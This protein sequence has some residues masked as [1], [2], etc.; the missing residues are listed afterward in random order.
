MPLVCVIL[1]G[2]GHT[3]VLI[4]ALQQS[5]A[6]TLYA[7][8]EPEPTHWGQTLYDVPIRGDDAFLPQLIQEGV[9]SFV[10]GVGSLGDATLRRRLFDFGLAHGLEAI[11]VIHPNAVISERAQLGRGVQVLAG[12]IINAGTELGDN[13]LI[14]T[15][16]IIEHDCLIE[17]DVH[18]ATGAKLAGTVRVGRGAHIGAG[19]SIRHKITIGAGAVVGVGAAVVKDVPPLT[20]VVGVPARPL[21][22]E[23]Q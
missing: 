10:V 8:L 22:A 17:D 12:S 2:G 3:R 14:N 6:A 7:V 13:V 19:A 16:A 21:R 5:K 9:N 4:D 1:G 15:G 20:V 18:V 23:D 11:N